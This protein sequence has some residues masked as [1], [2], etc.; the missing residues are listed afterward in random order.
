MLLSNI[1]ILLLILIINHFIQDLKP[2]FISEISNFIALIQIKMF[3]NPIK[4]II[5]L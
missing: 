4:D 5:T 2:E 3:K 1:N